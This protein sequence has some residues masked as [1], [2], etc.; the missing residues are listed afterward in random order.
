MAK[1]RFRKRSRANRIE[2]GR[3]SGQLGGATWSDL[4]R[5]FFEA[6]PPDDPEPPAEP[7]RFDDLLPAAQPDRTVPRTT[8]LMAVLSGAGWSR[9][10]VAVGLASLCLLICL[11]AVVVVLRS[12]DRTT[13]PAEP[14]CPASNAGAVKSPSGSSIRPARPAY[15]S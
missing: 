15:A 5:E 2:A 4:D 12:V 13:S 1:R 14:A 3:S 6:A 11:V 9:R 7:P 8:R 10:R